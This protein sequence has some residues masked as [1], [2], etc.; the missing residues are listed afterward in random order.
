M[1]TFSKGP[2]LAAW[3]GQVVGFLVGWMCAFGSLVAV[4]ALTKE[5][6]RELALLGFHGEGH[7]LALALYGG[8]VG[9]AAELAVPSPV[10]RRRCCPLS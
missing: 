8:V 10:R 7:R 2:D 4:Y 1:S 5:A 3:T 6:R 9:A